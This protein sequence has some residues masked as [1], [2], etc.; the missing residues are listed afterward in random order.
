[1]PALLDR[2][3]QDDADPFPTWPELGYMLSKRSA[4]VGDVNS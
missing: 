3:L 2:L 1:V 4:H